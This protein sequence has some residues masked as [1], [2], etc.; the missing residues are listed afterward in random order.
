MKKIVPLIVL[1]MVMFTGNAYAFQVTDVYW[2]QYDTAL[3]QLPVK[4]TQSGNAFI[5]KMS[6]SMLTMFLLD[7]AMPVA[8]ND[9]EMQSLIKLAAGRQSETWTVQN[10]LFMGGAGG[11][12]GAYLLAYYQFLWLYNELLKSGFYPYPGYSIPPSETIYFAYGPYFQYRSD[13]INWLEKLKTDTTGYKLGTVYSGGVASPNGWSLPSYNAKSFDDTGYY[14][15]NGIPYNC[16]SQGC[17]FSPMTYASSGSGLP[18]GIEEFYVEDRYVAPPGAPSEILPYPG[19]GNNYGTELN[20]LFITKQYFCTEALCGPGYD[21]VRVVMQTYVFYAEDDSEAPDQVTV[22]SLNGDI[23]QRMTTPEGGTAFNN[24]E[25][26]I[27]QKYGDS[28]TNNQN[29]SAQIQPYGSET[30][31]AVQTAGND[32]IM[33]LPQAVKNTISTQSTANQ[34]GSTVI[35][36][37]GS[38][39]QPSQ[40]TSISVTG[41]QYSPQRAGSD[42]VPVFDDFQDLFQTFINA[43]KNTTLFSLPGRFYNN[44]PTSNVCEMQIN[45]GQFFGTHTVSFCNWSGILAGFKAV[46]LVIFSYLAVRVIVLKD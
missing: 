2:S 30:G 17:S 16:T 1:L 38:Q 22:A 28:F 6:G 36:D 24:M 31:T 33:N 42:F 8:L 7:L 5:Y 10:R 20:G 37:S 13:A 15:S 26:A 40:Q 14:Y 41:G 9:G 23:A 35:G 44:I 32:V 45:C 27:Y 29:P 18:E 46:I 43:M 34:S 4:I 25:A 19:P 11:A 21:G 12:N 3:K 39:T